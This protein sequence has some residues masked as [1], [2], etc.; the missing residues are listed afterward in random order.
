MNCFMRYP[1]LSLLLSF[2][3]HPFL[4]AYYHISFFFLVVCVFKIAYLIILKTRVYSLR[5]SLVFIYGLLF[6][7]L[8]PLSYTKR[9]VPDSQWYLPLFCHVLI[10]D[11]LQDIVRRLSNMASLRTIEEYLINKYISSPQQKEMGLFSRQSVMDSQL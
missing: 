4:H 7:A 5:I 9:Q 6:Y 10:L 2:L 8:Q 11:R 1:S 3:H